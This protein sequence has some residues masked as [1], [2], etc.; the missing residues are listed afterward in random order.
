V[1]SKKERRRIAFGNNDQTKLGTAQD[2]RKKKKAKD[3]PYQGARK[4]TEI[5]RNK[6]QKSPN[7]PDEGERDP[8]TPTLG[9]SPNQ[10][11]FVFEPDLLETGQSNREK[12]MRKKGGWN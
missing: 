2:R 1:G 5:Q 3:C 6:R 4:E 7:A 9:G 11:M 8:T 10:P 12:E